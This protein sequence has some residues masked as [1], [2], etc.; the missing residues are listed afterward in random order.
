MD[1]TIGSLTAGAVQYSPGATTAPASTPPPAPVPVSGTGVVTSAASTDSTTVAAQVAT[2]VPQAK[3][4]AAPTQQQVQKAIDDINSAFSANVN[5]SKVQFAI[6]PG[7]KKL[8]VQMIDTENGKVISQ[9]PSE[10]IIEMGMALGQKLGQV[11]N[12]QA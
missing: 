8:V 2:P 10:E 6:D 5:T 1:V 9:F 12:Q 3:S 11:I 7:S 4:N